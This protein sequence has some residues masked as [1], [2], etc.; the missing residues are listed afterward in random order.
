M[1]DLTNSKLDR[2]N[3]LNNN[4]AI[5]AI[6]NEVKL[7]GII[8]D[9]EIRFTKKQIAEFYE[10]DERTINRYLENYYTELSHNGYVVLKGKK[11]K[12]FMETIK[13]VKDI[14]VLSI[15]KKTAQLGVF[16][17]K[18]FL[19]LGMIISDSEKAKII[20]SLILD[21]V[22]DIINQKTGGNTKY[23][24]QRDEDFISAAFDEECY[25]KEFTSALQECVVT[26]K[27]KF[28]VYTNKVYVSIFKENADEYRKILDLNKNEK[29]RDTLYSEVLVAIASYE[30]G[31]A[32]EIRKIYIDEGRKL[33]YSELDE[34]FKNFE[35]QAL[36]K[37]TLKNVRTKMASRD[38]AFRDALH[39]RLEN[40]IVPLEKEEFERFLGEKSKDLAERIEESKEVL[41][42]LK[43]RDSE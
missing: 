21:L 11:L 26:G 37:P 10:V 39:E 25:R 32:D 40:Y 3:L 38:L 6:Q 14:D 4:I 35:N 42:R 43:E 22:L 16:N 9:N 8:F 24:N 18:S 13:N 1:K 33:N 27:Y 28:G 23:I 41:K 19:N 17:F 15:S 12:S 7:P 34:I 36:W 29:I 2:Q 31:L 20:R 5:N 30:C